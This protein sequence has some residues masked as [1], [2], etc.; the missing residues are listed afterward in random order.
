[1]FIAS[2]ITVLLA[3]AIACHLLARSRGASAVFW[4]LM[5]STF[6]PLAIPFV[7]FSRGKS[8]P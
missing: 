2:L 1:M 3:S 5:G 7:L 8:F 4:G 6:G